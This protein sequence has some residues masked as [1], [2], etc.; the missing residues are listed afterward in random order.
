[1]ANNAVKF[2][3]NGEIVVSAGLVNNDGEKVTARFSVRDTGIG[4]TPEQ[5]SR[6]FK[7][8]KQA[9]ASTTRKYGGT[10]LGLTISKRLVEMMNGGIEVESRAGEGSEFIFTAQFGLG[11]EDAGRALEPPPGSAGHESPGGGRQRHQPGDF[12]RHA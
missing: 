8:F 6:L 11:R 10:G 1:M 7:A 9:D 4:L 2:T 12:E 3:E 5:K